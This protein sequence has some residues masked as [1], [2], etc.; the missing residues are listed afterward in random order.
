[1]ILILILTRWM[2]AAAIIAAW[3]IAASHFDKQRFDSEARHQV[4]EEMRFEAAAHAM[5]GINAS[6]TDL[7]DN[8]VQCR[9]HR[10]G[11]TRIAKVQL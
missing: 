11:K 4:S 9:T 10:G 5:C 7:G 3:M 1:M 8:R 6:F 2:I